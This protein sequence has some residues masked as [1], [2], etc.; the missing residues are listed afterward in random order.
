M[1]VALGAGV[2]CLDFLL[3][4]YE[5]DMDTPIAIASAVSQVYRK[6]R[7]LITVAVMQS[8]VSIKILLSPRDSN[9]ASQSLER[10][11]FT[12]NIFYFH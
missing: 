9:T 7:T 5:K 1:L 4:F 11:N 10:D 3:L 12:E 8:F 6:Y 2:L